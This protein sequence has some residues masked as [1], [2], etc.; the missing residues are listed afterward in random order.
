MENK[1]HPNDDKQEQHN[2]LARENLGNEPEEMQEGNPESPYKLKHTLD[3]K[4]PE[5]GSI[6]KGW[7]VDSNTSRGP[8][9]LKNDAADEQ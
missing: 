9:D 1:Q 5:D 6:E 7:D 2:D 8:E 3:D 4:R